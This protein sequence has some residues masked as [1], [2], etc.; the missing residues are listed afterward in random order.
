[1]SI[2]SCRWA[3]PKGPHASFNEGIDLA[4]A[5]YLIIL[6]ADDIL[7]PGIL[8]IGMQLLENCP[9]AACVIGTFEGPWTG[10][11]LLAPC[12]PPQWS[13][14][15]GAAFIGRCC[16]GFGQDVPA[17]AILSRTSVQKA[18][19][20]YRPALT[21]MDDL[22]MLLRLANLGPVLELGTQLVGKRL[23]SSNLSEALWQDRLVDLRER[24]TAFDSF[25][26]REGAG[27]GLAPLH[28][29]VRRRLAEAAFWSAVSH[30][31]RGRGA[32]GVR[33]RTV[34]R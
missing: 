21:H 25:F 1:M 33:A 5:D 16:L 30:L 31:C 19:G 28:R 10:E 9:E 27:P 23:H 4:R 6:C 20:H 34:R 3:H 22:E 13:R 12:E 14:S 15:E 17:Y 8:S 2:A 11:P 26:E 7:A 29:T 32:D 24:E 18:A